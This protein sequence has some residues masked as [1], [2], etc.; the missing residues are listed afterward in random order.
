MRLQLGGFSSLIGKMSYQQISQNLETSKLK[1]SGLRPRSFHWRFGSAA[2][3][4]PV[5][6]KSNTIILILDLAA[7]R[8]YLFTRLDGKTSHRLVNKELIIQSITTPA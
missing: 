2:A 3:E 5:K 1:F 8:L 7:S 6:F 4:A